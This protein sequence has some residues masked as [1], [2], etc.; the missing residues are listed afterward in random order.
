VADLRVT[1]G[2]PLLVVEM[3]YKD[4]NQR[5]VEYSIARHP[6]DIFSIRY[7]APNDLI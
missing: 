6:A 2:S 4:A 3:L 1:K 5:N 7:D